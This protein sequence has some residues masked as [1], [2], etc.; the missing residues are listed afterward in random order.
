MEFTFSSELQARHSLVDELQGRRLALIEAGETVIDLSMIN[1]DLA[2]PRFALDRLI[3]A[4]MK[5][6][7][8]RYPVSRGIRKLREAFALKYQREFS[9]KVDPAQNVC[10]TMG[11]KDAVLQSLRVLIRPGDRVLVPSPTYP[12]YLGFLSLLGASPIFYDVVADQ[13]QMLAAIIKLLKEESPRGVI[14]NFPHNPTGV[15][16]DQDFYNELVSAANDSDVFLLNDFVYGELCFDRNS[17]PASLLSTETKSDRLVEVYSL[18]KAYSV[19]GW[20]VGAVLGSDKIVSAVARLKSVIDYGVFLPVQHAAA[21]ALSST[22]ALAAEVAAQYNERSNFLCA[23]LKKAGWE[24]FVPA[25]GASVWARLPASLGSGLEYCKNLLKEK[26][27]LALPG[28]VFGGKYSDFVRFALV[29]PK[30][31]LSEA[32]KLR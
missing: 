22:E 28:E 16:V 29:A 9:V 7:N 17:K 18:S 8:H 32:I 31:K 27:V 21:A 12:S 4:S 20:R 26:H 24:V 3:E 23:A 2:P 6:S 25:A 5:T 10:V 1:P 19:P 11:S 30:E 13:Q 15:Y 14:L